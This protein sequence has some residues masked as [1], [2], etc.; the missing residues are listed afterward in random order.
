MVEIKN[1][2]K[3]Y[4]L[5]KKQMAESHTK[6]P[7]KRAV[8]GLSLTAKP[9]EIYGLLGPNGAGKRQPCVVFQRSLN[10][11]RGRFM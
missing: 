3:I 10:P 6:D 1:L 2:T 4:K 7:Y 11:Q 5:N 9:G 8:D